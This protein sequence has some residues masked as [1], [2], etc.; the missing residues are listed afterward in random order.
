[1]I[2]AA[3]I[4][5]AAVA[6]FGS[7]LS[8]P[9]TDVDPP[10]T[11]DVSGANQDTG[12]C[13]RVAIGYPAT[14]AV[15][16]RASAPF[17]GVIRRV[18]VRAGTPGALRVLVVRLR[19]V[20]REGGTGQGRAV[21]RSALLR[22][23]GRGSAAR[24]AIESFRVRLPV[25]R[26]DYLALEG[27]SFS[28]LRCEGGD[29][30]ELLFDPLRS[31][32]PFADSSER[33]NCTALV[34]ATV[35]RRRAPAARAAANG[36]ISAA[37]PN[38]YVNSSVTIDQGEKVTFTNNDAVQHDVTARGTGP[39]GGPLFRSELTGTGQTSDVK[40]TEYLTTGDYDFV[41]SIH[42]QMTGTLHVSSAGT[43]VPRPSSGGS[44]GSG[45]DTT[46]PALGLRVLDSR[47]SSVR[48]AR[49]LRVRVSVDEPATV[50]L[51][52]RAGRTALGAATVKLGAAGARR[53]SL[54]LTAAG[55]R[56]ARRSTHLVVS[57]SARAA[58][59]AG[60]AA[61]ARASRTLRR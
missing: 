29:V 56:L 40:G 49:L 51:T 14:G 17:A 3:T 20:D 11:C 35:T 25:G 44:P 50:R 45:A 18:R 58:D 31:P 23:E 30:E 52:A 1:L 53:V 34:Q 54:K 39:D 5:A 27:S 24:H 43:P 38:Q 59:A 6:T 41:C 28:A 46:R 4:A 22:V 10:A 16:G 55:A 7:T 57:L 15:A 42:P 33:D 60:N 21:S 36:Q 37:P 2:A 61:T 47:L 8:Q 9:P 13:T 12:P 19:A 26:G 32:A 48:R